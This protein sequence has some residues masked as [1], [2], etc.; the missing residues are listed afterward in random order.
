[1][2]RELAPITIFAYRRIDLL[3]RVIEALQDN[4]YAK[5]SDIYIFSDGP[6]GEHDREEVD[7]VREYTRRIE[8]FNRVTVI[9][10]NRNYGLAQNI[11]EGVTDIVDKYGK[12]IVLED[13]ILTCRYF[14]KYMN[15]ALNLYENENS[16]MEISGYAFPHGNEGVPETAFIHFADCWGWATWR[17]AWDCFEKDPEGIIRSFSEDDIY[18]FN[19]DGCYPFWDQVLSNA[20]GQLDTW[21][22]FWQA[23][24][25]MKNGL[26]LYP[27][28]SLIKNIG[29]D[30]S[31]ENCGIASGYSS[32]MVDKPI[33]VFPTEIEENAFV[34]NM[35]GNYLAKLG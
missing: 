19:L 15:D 2:S 10:R 28:K 16:V 34:R 20:N 11:I 6:R 7:R 27:T 13:D 24:V 31:G 4:I 35:I 9:E 25:Y 3:H 17:R 29:L 5:E 23:S 30:G 14:L 26:M 12:I 33:E 18:K 8:G 21:A 1:M 32:A 22:I